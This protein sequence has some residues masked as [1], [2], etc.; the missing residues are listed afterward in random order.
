MRIK[1]SNYTI[2]ITALLCAGSYIFIAQGSSNL[3]PAQLE[4]LTRLSN[5][6]PNCTQT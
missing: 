2:V 1:L 4:T 5:N 6:N 3:T